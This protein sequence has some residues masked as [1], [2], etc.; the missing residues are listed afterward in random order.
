MKIKD[1][2]EAERPRERLLR[3]GVGVLSDAELN[4]KCEYRSTIP[5]NEIKDE[6][7]K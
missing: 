2:A 5:T 3:E 1:M 6:V 4:A 7:I